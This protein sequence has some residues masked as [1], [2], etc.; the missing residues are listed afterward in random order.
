MKIRQLRFRN[1]NSFYGEHPP[2][3]FLE[4]ALATTGL[5]VISG[6]TGAGKS[7]LLDVIT[8][9]LF[10]R[11]PRISG[12]ISNT[13]ILAEGLIVNQQA[14]QEPNA[15][16]Y[17]EVE[18]EAN[19]K[20]YRSRWSI[21]KNRNGNW[22]NYEMEV[23]HLPEGQ[24]E[25]TLFPIKNLS[26]FPK[27]NE[28]LIG[29]TYEQ[30]I[31]S[32]V[33]AQGAFDQ[34]LK[35]RA[36]ERSKMLEKITGTE[37][38]R[39]L[40]MRAYAEAKQFD[41]R[42]E[43]TRQTALL[44]QVLDEDKI[45]E[46]K[47]QQKGIDGQ[48]KVLDKNVER[49]TNE[50][51]LL[52]K[53]SEAE[54][55]LEALAQRQQGLDKRRT[56]FATH[57]QRLAQHAI[58]SDLTAD[59]TTIQ[60]VEEQLTK[61]MS[62]QDRTLR[63][64]GDLENDLVKVLSEGRALLGVDTFTQDQFIT[65]LQQFQERVLQLEQAEKTERDNIRRPLTSAGQ[66]IQQ[67]AD[68]DLQRLDLDAPGVA[69]AHVQQHQ[70]TTLAH[71]ATLSTEYAT[72]TPDTLDHEL[73][74]LVMQGRQY[75]QLVRLL[76]E[77][78]NRL[79]EG[80]NLK[81]KAEDHEQ[82]VLA[83]QAIT[84]RLLDELKLLETAKLA[85]E[86]KQRRLDTEA[87]LDE[88]RKGLT[89]G[90]PCP[91]CGSL[92]HPYA[93]HYVQQTGEIRLKLRVTTA[94][95]DAKRAETEQSQRRLIE[96]QSNQKAFDSYRD[97]LRQE[98][99]KNR[100][101]LNKD[102]VAVALE[103]DIQPME[104]HSTI[105]LLDLQRQD[106]GRLQSFWQQR[107]LLDRLMND[108]QLIQTSI[109][110]ADEHRN[111][112]SALY[113]GSDIRGHCTRLLTS[114]N[115]V[116]QQL[117]S[118]QTLL[119]TTE[120]TLSSAQ[121]ELTAKQNNVLSS[122]QER[123]FADVT[124]ARDC[125]L[126]PVT[127][128][129]F[130]ETQQAIQREE[131]DVNQRTADET[132]RRNEALDARKETGTPDEIDKQLNELI[133]KQ[134]QLLQ[135]RGYVKKHLEQDGAERKRQQKM[136]KQL[137]DLEQK[138]QPWRELAKLIGSAKGDEFSKFAQGL[139]LSQ[140]IGLSNRRLHELT[141]RYLLLKPRDGQEE[142]YVVD[143]YQGNAE[144]SVSSLSGGETFTLSLSLALGLSD[145]ASQNVQINSL[146]IDEGFGTLDP[147]ALDTAI[148]MLEKLQHDSQKTIGIISHRHEIKERISVQI[149]VEKGIDGNSR[150]RI[151]G[152]GQ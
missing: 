38:Y 123:G 82:A 34:F 26:D 18:Y 23:A 66:I 91:L 63:T 59:L 81:S 105:K 139:T 10:N 11:V 24:T 37:I 74:Q 46:L 28:E 120:K 21:K 100:E 55:T 6:P 149:Q 89:S 127:A 47:V 65:T 145:L 151:S 126:D 130:G 9:A 109:Q 58:V 49:F 53:L 14:L 85:L 39:Q 64:I 129:R 135:D 133:G 83:E 41:A 152:S 5:F 2:I 3:Q 87:N 52:Q 94:D 88:L 118:Q 107:D 7:T 61:L 35:A 32:I 13:S 29:L 22:N 33:L 84:S 68:P 62:Q 102:L 95:W 143:L 101:K 146:F 19:G 44:I 77:Q 70:Q 8:L 51:Q 106:L 48:L 148:V 121:Q 12:L 103:P 92:S 60:S 98:F 86:E 16:S 57:A 1:I 4:G 125:L 97:E 114:F 142:L 45:A 76:E 25:G 134:R 136:Q 69:L 31:R 96:A 116:T 30:F 56:D 131:A 141:D 99:K 111:N 147:E 144:R 90:E 124:S 137:A 122:L 40:S 73:D 150:L 50:R 71:L 78:Q 36:A 108:L 79:A 43:T 27:K 17:A 112:R 140:L 72:I 20:T 15:A 93:Q 115:D 42:I 128:R 80:M 75:A 113:K 54:R 117:A 67:F 138:A 132:T 119:K 104:L 110:R